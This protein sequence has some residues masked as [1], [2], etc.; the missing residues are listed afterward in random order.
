MVPPDHLPPP[1][2]T[3]APMKTPDPQ[4]PNLSASLTETEQ[5]PKRQTGTHD[6]TE[7]ADVGDIVME[8]SSDLLCNPTTGAVTKNYLKELRSE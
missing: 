4:L 5:T 7:P 8:Y 6:G 1:L 2:S 3:S